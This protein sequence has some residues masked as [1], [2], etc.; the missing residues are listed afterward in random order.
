MTW[1]LNSKTVSLLGYPKVIPYTKFEHFAIIRFV[2]K[3]CSGQTDK[4]TDTNILPKPTTMVG[5]GNNQQRDVASNLFYGAH[6][7]ALKRKLSY[8]A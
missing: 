2:F 5:M 3:L 8:K 6:V 4:Q 1:P 7:W